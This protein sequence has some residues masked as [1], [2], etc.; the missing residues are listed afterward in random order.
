MKSLFDNVSAEC[1]KITT[2]AY[3]TSFSTGIYFLNRRL[4]RPIY[5][6]YGFVR[7]AD[8]IVDSFHGYDKEY[9]LAKFANDTYDAI[10]NKISLNP[11]LNS[12][13]EAVHE[14]DIDIEL[15]DTFLESMEMD[16]EKGEFDKAKYNK[17]ILGSAEV[18]GLMCLHVFT[19]GDKEK[20]G[21]LKEA[22]MKLGSAFQK[23]N[24]LRDVKQD[25]EELG[26]T[27]FP[28]VNLE[29]LSVEEKQKIEMEIEEEFRAA[30]DGIKQLPVG[31]R[32]GVYLAYYYYRN[33]F[34]KIKNVSPKR[35]MTERVRIPNSMKLFLM[36]KSYLRYQSNML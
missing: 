18:V 8:E 3:S 9:L 19:E 21:Q 33:L 14:Y 13:Q 24:F 29:K 1:S 31:S 26:R 23:V 15:I 27:Y 12:F 2:R 36:F 10:A 35:I 30:L 5:A 20:Y 28:G 6:I 4:H 16:V 22:A 25:Y 34:N 17:Y 11:I 32:G 7:F